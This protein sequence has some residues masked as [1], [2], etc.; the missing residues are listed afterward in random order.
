MMPLSCCWPEKNFTIVIANGNKKAGEIQDQMRQHYQ[1]IE[2]NR[3]GAK[4]MD[5]NTA[6]YKQAHRFAI[7]NVI[8][9]WLVNVGG[10][11][12]FDEK[13]IP[14]CPSPIGSATIC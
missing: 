9:C 6:R 5:C 1:G 13:N 8:M 10:K 14:G 2:H 7:G 4:N 11:K 3:I 12:D